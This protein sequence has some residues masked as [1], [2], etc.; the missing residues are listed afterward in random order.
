M[1]RRIKEDWLLNVISTIPIQWIVN[2]TLRLE[3][4]HQLVFYDE[5]KEKKRKKEKKNMVYKETF[6][7]DGAIYW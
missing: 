7:Q 2:R 3:E 1:P 5:T 6:D 4:S